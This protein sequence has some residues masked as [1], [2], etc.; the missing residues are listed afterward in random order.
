METCSECTDAIYL[1]WIDTTDGYK[2]FLFLI[3]KTLTETKQGA[4]FNVPVNS[5][6]Y[7]SSA[8]FKNAKQIVNRPTTRGYIVS[9]PSA[10]LA[11]RTHIRGLFESPVVWMHSGY[12]AG[13]NDH[14]WT[15][16]ILSDYTFETERNGGNIEI[17][18]TVNLPDI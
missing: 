7:N 15:E 18:F 5:L 2:Y 17:Q 12:V 10:D 4:P 1:R 16:V 3:G 14:L 6:G 13:D 11:K 8:V 9:E